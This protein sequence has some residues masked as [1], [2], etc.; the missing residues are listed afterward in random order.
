[1]ETR[2][3]TLRCRAA[4]PIEPPSRPGPRMESLRSVIDFLCN[5]K[6]FV[7]QHK[8]ILRIV[9][10][11]SGVRRLWGK[12]AV[13][14]LTLEEHK[15]TYAEAGEFSGGSAGCCRCCLSVELMHMARAVVRS[16]P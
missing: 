8:G 5:S 3:A 9:A 13:R 4:R 11:A 2:F 10:A 16:G 15:E 6:L 7:W 1:M 14:G 12:A